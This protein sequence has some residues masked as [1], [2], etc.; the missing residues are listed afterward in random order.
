MNITDFKRK[1]NTGQKITVLTCYDFSA[2]QLIE[3]TAIDCV[4]VGDSAAMVVHGHPSTTHANMAMMTLHTA[5][6]ARGIKTKFILADLP[7]L[8]HRMGLNHTMQ[9]VQAL[10]QSGAHAVKLEGAGE[11]NLNTIKHIV[12]SGIPVMGHLGLTPQAIHALGGHKVQGKQQVAAALIKQQAHDL[13]QAGCFAIVLECI[14]AQLAAA[15]TQEL[16]IPTI[17]IGAGNQTDGQ[18][19]VWQDLLGFN[20]HFKPKFL[21][22]FANLEHIITTSIAQYV[23][24]VQLRQYPNT[25][26]EY[27]GA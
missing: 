7:F 3:Q 20:T 17:G 24:E 22:H 25:E 13:E 15:I 21:K 5:A 23:S 10:I 6:V 12:D 16:S 18:V 1:K 26:H 2:A 19:L 11:S 9:Q 27:Q 14:P 4:L 8:S